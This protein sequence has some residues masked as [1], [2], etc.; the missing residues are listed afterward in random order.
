MSELKVQRVILYMALQ[1]LNDKV[2]VNDITDQ[3]IISDDS[4]TSPVIVGNKGGADDFIVKGYP[5]D[6]SCAEFFSI[7]DFQLVSELISDVIHTVTKIHTI[8]NRN[9]LT[10][11]EVSYLLAKIKQGM[12]RFVPIE[13]REAFVR[14]LQNEVTND[15]KDK[16]S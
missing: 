9:A 2:M 4:E 7:K 12:D 3:A 15:S 13:N 6:N 11:T 14:W 16:S 10:K 8:H 5:A 1:S